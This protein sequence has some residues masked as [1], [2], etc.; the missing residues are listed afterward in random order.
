VIGYYLKGTGAEQIPMTV[1]FLDGRGFTTLAESAGPAAAMEI[2]NQHMAI[3]LD[4]LFAHRGSCL[5]F[6][7]DGLLV[8]FGLRA[9]DHDGHEGQ[10]LECSLAIQ[11]AIKDYHAEC[12]SERQ[13]RFGIGISTGKVVLGAVG[14]KDR[15]DVAIVGDTVNTAQRVMTMARSGEILLTGQTLAAVGNR[16]EVEFLE[17]TLVKGKS[18]KVEVFKLVGQKDSHDDT[19]PDPSPTVTCADP[20][21]EGYPIEGGACGMK[22]CN[23]G[24]AGCP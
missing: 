10:S 17:S 14:I 7:G 5:K 22:D 21:K 6:L 19:A 16:F 15:R 1:V 2:V 23:D 18:E 9:E 12:S 24:D 3:I 20:D 4:V 13:L 8:S 11:R